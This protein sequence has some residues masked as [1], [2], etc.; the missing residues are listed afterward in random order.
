MVTL[1]VIEPAGGVGDDGA[2]LDAL[3]ANTHARVTD[4]FRELGR[5][6]ATPGVHQEID[7]QLDHDLRAHL[8]S[9][10]QVVV[11]ELTAPERR[12]LD[13]DRLDLL[14]ALDTYQDHD[15]TESL[16]HL[17]NRFCDHVD[18]EEVTVLGALGTRVGGRKM[19]TL[20]FRYAEVADTHLDARRRRGTGPAVGVGRALAGAAAPGVVHRPVRS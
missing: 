7:R 18:L 13:E 14:A 5:R 11:P 16:R 9:V 3:V 8:Q 2:L 19:A 10:E 6:P 12:A 20:G 15:D 4:L 17:L 1:T